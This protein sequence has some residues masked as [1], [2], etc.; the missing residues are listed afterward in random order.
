MPKHEIG[1]MGHNPR[2]IGTNQQKNGLFLLLL[3]IISLHD[4]SAYRIHRSFQWILFAR[5]GKAGSFSLPQKAD[6]PLAE[7]SGGDPALLPS[8]SPIGG[9]EARK[10]STSLRKF[11]HH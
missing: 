4:H 1:H 3:W 5:T 7:K 2:T 9:G 10:P 8:P 11:I 6:P